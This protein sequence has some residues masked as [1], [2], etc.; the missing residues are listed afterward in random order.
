MNVSATLINGSSHQAHTGLIQQPVFI[1]PRFEHRDFG[2][3]EFSRNFCPL[4]TGTHHAGIGPFTQHQGQGV[5]QDRLAGAGFTGQHS[6]ARLK[7]QR[8]PI[9]N[10]KIPDT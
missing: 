6:E 3:I 7:L 10:D 1:Q 4:A 2:A 9:N 5:D 8:Q